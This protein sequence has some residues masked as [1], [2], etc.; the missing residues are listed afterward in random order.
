M[1]C[2]RLANTCVVRL[3]GF[4]LRCVTGCASN[5]RNPRLRIER[6]APL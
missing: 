2:S 3:T 5:D 1:S 4:S 6:A